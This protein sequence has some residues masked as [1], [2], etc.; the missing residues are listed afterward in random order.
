[1][2]TVQHSLRVSVWLSVVLVDQHFFMGLNSRP[3]SS[4]LQ[5]LYGVRKRKDQIFG[6]FSLFTNYMCEYHLAL[7]FPTLY[8]LFVWIAASVLSSHVLSTVQRF[9]LLYRSH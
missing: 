1:M 3:H 6:K 4:A 8:P 5:V 2:V 9:M 7:M